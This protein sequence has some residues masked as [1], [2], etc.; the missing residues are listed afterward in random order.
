MTFRGKLTAYGMSLVLLLGVP[1]L[2]IE[3]QRPWQE[4]DSLLER[5]EALLGGVAPGFDVNDLVVMNDFA[6]DTIAEF[7]ADE[8][9]IHNESRAV[10]QARGGGISTL[11]S[12]RSAGNRS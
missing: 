9:A 12:W 2:L 3:I 8:D 6:A 7:Y 11:C 1:F 5:T 10:R 4:L